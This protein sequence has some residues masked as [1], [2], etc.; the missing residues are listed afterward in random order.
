M[1]ELERHALGG[2]R[3]D[4]EVGEE[5]ADFSEFGLHL[6]NGRLHLAHEHLHGHRLGLLRSEHPLHVGVVGGHI[7]ELE[8]SLQLFESTID[9]VSISGVSSGDGDCN[10]HTHALH[11]GI[12]GEDD[13]NFGL[14]EEQT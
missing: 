7:G 2:Y 8:L 6:V 13:I 5:V 14:A 12:E 3:L 10:L 11:V 1:V 9:V 4:G